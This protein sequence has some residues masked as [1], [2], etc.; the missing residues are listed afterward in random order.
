MNRFRF[1]HVAVFAMMSVFLLVESAVAVSLR[2]CVFIV[3]PITSEKSKTLFGKMA[4]RLEQSGN[5]LAA[6]VFKSFAEN[7]GSGS[8]FIIRHETGRYYL[9]TNRHVVGQADAVD[10][11]K[12]DSTKKYADCRV[13]YVDEDF[14]LAVIDIP[15]EFCSDSAG[16]VLDTTLQADGTK[17]HAIGFP[18]LLSRPSWQTSPGEITNSQARVPELADPKTT[19]IIQH[20]APIDPGNSGGPLLKDRDGGGIGTV[21]IGVNTWKI[22]G[23]E[24]TNFALPARDVR[25]VLEQAEH[26]RE[27]VQ[28][29]DS[30]KKSLNENSLALAEELSTS[31]MGDGR[32]YRY[33]SYGWVATQGWDNFETLLKYA[34]DQQAAYFLASVFSYDPLQAMKLSIYNNF[35]MALRRYGDN[36][37][38]KYLGINSTDAQ[39]FKCFE[40]TRTNFLIAKEAMEVEWSF[41][42]GHWRIDGIKIG[43]DN[44]QV[45][46]FDFS[47][48][49]KITLAA[50]PYVIRK[51]HSSKLSWTSSNSTKISF[52]PDFGVAMSDLAGSCKIKPVTTTTYIVKAE[53][54]GGTFAAD[55]ATV[56]VT[57][58]H[59]H[60]GWIVFCG[61]ATVGSILGVFR[62]NR[63]V[64]QNTKNDRKVYENWREICIGTSWVFGFGFAL[65]LTLDIID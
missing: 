16:L 34:G 49:V 32:F 58:L 30:L 39:N 38:L 44:P 23:R 10:I 65:S 13:L 14:D 56:T 62:L 2:E 41:E 51:G 8:G 28:N 61:M 1:I 24:N 37:T 4:V 60:P 31:S 7:N 33:I 29:Q 15:Q 35:R 63:E 3:K 12:E 17:V 40:R 42:H 57:P 36:S 6:K 27:T 26:V 47:S 18:G 50:N 22:I 9:I 54:F 5:D 21:V 64:Q 20:S 45:P 59:H 52:V 48:L 55:T 25:Y 11:L 53:G 43:I 19:Y 46:G